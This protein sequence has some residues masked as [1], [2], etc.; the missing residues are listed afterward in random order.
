MKL[1]YPTVSLQYETDISAIVFA[2]WSYCFRLYL[3]DM[4][5][6]FKWWVSNVKLMYQ[7]MV[8]QQQA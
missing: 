2:V 7:V 3:C 6:V 1:I 5:S 4:K 8:L